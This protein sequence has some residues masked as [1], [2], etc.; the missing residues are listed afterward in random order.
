M[1]EIGPRDVKGNTLLVRTRNKINGP[2]WKQIVPFDDFVSGVS[3]RLKDF[4]SDLFNAANTRLQE[5]QVTDIKTAEEMQ[6]YFSRQNSWIGGKGSK[7]AFVRGKWSE[8]S[9]SI[10]KM[11]EMKISI[12]C[13]PEDQSH[14]EGNCLLT[15]KKAKLDVIYARAY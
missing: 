13:I 7:V 4:N 8:D 3:K 11:K 5:N 10:D 2:E 9:E 1:C 12:R 14:E 15:N 6:E